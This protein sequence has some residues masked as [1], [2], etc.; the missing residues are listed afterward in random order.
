MPVAN[1][2]S[3]AMTRASWIRKMFERGTEMTRVH[4]A[5][6]VFD[7]TLGNPVIEP[8]AAFYDELAA[9]AARRGEGLHRY[10]QNAGFPTV[11]AAIAERLGRD[12]PGIEAGGVIMCVGAGG[13]L[14]ATLK[15]VLNPG[16]E[17]VILAPYFVEYNFYIQNHGG[18]PVVAQT[19]DT[20]DIDPDALAAVITEKTRAVLVNSPNN[21]TGRLYPRASLEAL[22]RVLAD[23]EARIGHPIYLLSDEPYREIVY[24][25]DP[26]PSASTFHPNSFLIYSWSKSL[27]IPGER[28]GYIAVNPAT[29]DPAGLAGAITFT[30]RTLGFVNAPATMQLIAAR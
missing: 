29:D 11:R 24:V 15:A 7:F 26:P 4:G 25:D 18:V 21:P 19:G 6:N 8:P 10:M 5:N 17:V 30:N 14:N 20:F 27:S 28:I 13:G 22:G 3:E 12:F 9:I 16:D 2:I 1:A 23:A